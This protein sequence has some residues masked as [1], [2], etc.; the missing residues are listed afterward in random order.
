M[1]AEADMDAMWKLRCAMD[2]KQIANPGK[3]FPTGESPALRMTGLHPL[4]RAGVIS[5]E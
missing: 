3:M 2:P 5:R 4:E 1:Y